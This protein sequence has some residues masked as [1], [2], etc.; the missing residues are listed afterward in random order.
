VAGVPSGLSLSPHIKKLKKKKVEYLIRGK[1]IKG[2]EEMEEEFYLP[3]HTGKN[4]S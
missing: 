1:R 2:E 4:L 3:V